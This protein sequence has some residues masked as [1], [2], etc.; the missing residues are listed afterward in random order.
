[1][2]SVE[3]RDRLITYAVTEDGMLKGGFSAQGKRVYAI[4]MSRKVT[5]DKGLMEQE[6][7]VAFIIRLVKGEIDR[8]MPE[9]VASDTH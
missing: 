8:L 6:D 1:M 5:I 7:P 2:P 3:Y 9:L 4:E